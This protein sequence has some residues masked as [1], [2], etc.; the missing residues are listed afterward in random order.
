MRLYE[1]VASLYV[2]EDV[3]DKLTMDTFEAAKRAND[4]SDS[5]G[6]YMLRT[7]WK[8]NMISFMA[9][10]SVHQVILAYGYYI[11]IQEQRRRLKVSPSDY[12]DQS[13]H[14]GSIAISFLRKST[15][16]AVSRIVGLGF[17]SIG[18]ALGSTVWPGWGTL[19]GSNV[20]DS[21][22]LQLTEDGSAGQPSSTAST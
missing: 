10:Y 2:T 8:A 21:F 12:L 20:G 4:T 17:S 22:A 15:L 7:C 6:P 3:L 9:D 16:L 5:I 1:H 14:H 11:Y 18:G 19:V 13:L